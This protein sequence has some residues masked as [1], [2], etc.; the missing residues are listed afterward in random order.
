MCMYVLT[1]FAFQYTYVRMYPTN[2]YTLMVLLCLISPRTLKYGRCNYLCENFTP[3][4]YVYYKWLK[5]VAIYTT[6]C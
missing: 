4:K 6:F 1:S 3:P 5:I 2:I